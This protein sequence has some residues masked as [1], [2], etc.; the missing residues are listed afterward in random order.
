MRGSGCEAADGVNELAACD[1][2][3]VKGSTRAQL[4]AARAHVQRLLVSI[5]LTDE[6]RAAVDD[7]RRAPDAPLVR[8]AD[9]AT[10]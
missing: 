5:A 2:W 9:M 4:A 10:H 6:E 7:G 1:P 3:S 8:P